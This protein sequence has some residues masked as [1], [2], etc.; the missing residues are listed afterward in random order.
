MSRQRVPLGKAARA[1]R[2]V[3]SGRGVESSGW[4]DID[5]LTRATE[6]ILNTADHAP[7]RFT[8]PPENDFATSVTVGAGPIAGMAVGGDPLG[9]D[10]GDRS[11]GAEERLGGSHIAG[12][13]QVDV[14]QVAVT[15]DR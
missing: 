1:T 10:L 15:I 6:W 4:S 3:S 7:D 13:T 2:R 11:G 9:L 8:N 12:F 14:D 5:R